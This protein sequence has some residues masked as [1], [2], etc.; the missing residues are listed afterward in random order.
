MYW[1][2]RLEIWTS[3][4]YVPV[5]RCLF[6]YHSPAR[7]VPQLVLFT[8]LSPRTIPQLVPFPSSKLGN[9]TSCGMVRGIRTGE[10]YKL[11]NGTGILSCGILR[12][13]YGAVFGIKRA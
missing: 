10:Q 1:A 11:G 8:S 4:T 6:P 9:G 2:L 5:P 13:T 7:T 3:A 12:G